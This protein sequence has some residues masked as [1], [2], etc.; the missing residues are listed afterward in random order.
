[1]TSKSLSE[2]LYLDHLVSTGVV[3]NIWLQSGT[4]LTGVI[5]AHSGGGDVLW[6]QPL[7]NH[8]DLAML[9]IHNISTISPVGSHGFGRRATQDFKGVVLSDDD[10]ALQGRLRPHGGSACM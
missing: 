7:T 4:R 2:Q 6:L 10:Q 5:A 1:M 8:D 3:C 9:Y